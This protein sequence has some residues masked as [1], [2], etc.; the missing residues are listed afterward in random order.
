MEQ[1][2]N[3]SFTTE[4]CILLENLL[5]EKIESIDDAILEVKEELE[6]QDQD[7]DHYVRNLQFTFEYE[8]KSKELNKLKT[9]IYKH[10]V[11]VFASPEWQ[12]QLK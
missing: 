9:K 3:L 1:K 11:K 12:A 7:S 5:D 4:E 6:Q 2:M 8:E 10:C